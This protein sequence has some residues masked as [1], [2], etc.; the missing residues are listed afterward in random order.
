MFERTTTRHVATLCCATLLAVA[1]AATADQ[2]QHPKGFTFDLPD[3]GT[4]WEQSTTG[5]VMV[6]SDESDTLPELEVFVFAPTTDGAFTDLERRLPTELTRNGVAPEGEH[7]TAMRFTGST[8]TETI[9]GATVRFGQATL[10]KDTPA[11]WAI[12]QRR[13]VSLIL[14]GVP[15]SG[16]FERGASNFRA[17]V[18]GLHEAA[19]VRP[20]AAKPLPPG[21][22]VVVKQ[23]SQNDALYV[24]QDGLSVPLFDPMFDRP[25]LLSEIKDAY[26][27]KDGT[28]LEVVAAGCD[29][30]HDD[31]DAPYE[32]P[33][34][35]IAA[36]FENLR[37]MQLQLKKHYADAIPHFAAA[38][39]SDP[40]AMYV[41]NLASAQSRAK[42][43][44]DA[45]R[46]LA[47]HA[48]GHEAWLLWRLA[49]DSDLTGVR[50]RP[51]AR[52]LVAPRPSQLTKAA[53]GDAV[54][55]SP[56]GFVAVTEWNGDRNDPQLAL[57]TL[58]RDTAELRIPAP[59]SRA[60]DPVLALGGFEKLP[61]TWIDMA[62]HDDL[63]V[64]VVSPDHQ[65][66]VDLG[67]ND[68]TIVRGA[69]HLSVQP[70]GRLLRVG[71][72]GPFVVI[73]WR[74]SGLD[75]CSGD[76]QQSASEVV[77]TD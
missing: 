2:L 55:V 29:T 11:I 10:N 1:S 12:V 26:V 24:E 28:M 71:F 3:I 13:G 67:G 60:I 45:A 22:K 16:I 42:L 59:T 9:A 8:V 49:V 30:S 53:L 5:D 65:T 21:M 76:L 14:L 36:R 64:P 61:T 7:V 54:A 56:L 4:P 41:T 18:H 33:L 37:G 19:P 70:E 51:A 68:I 34:A 50:D 69:K 48:K 75:G 73:T 31:P 15:K 58:G 77:R 62:N 66:T 74:E 32:V 40:N 72:A 23:V 43:L 46:T 63:R 39:K 27:S 47:D 17:I 57:Y 25:H 38:V 20:A 6:V 44:D 35:T 52:A